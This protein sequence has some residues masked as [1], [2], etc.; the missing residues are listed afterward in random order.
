MKKILVSIFLLY[1]FYPLWATPIDIETAKK[2]AKNFISQRR[3][4]P[5]EVL[6]VVIEKMNGE[7]SF[8]VVNFHEGGW[9][10]VSSDNSTVPVLAYSI[11]GTY[12]LEDQKPEA[13]IEIIESYKEVIDVSKDNNQSYPQ[14]IQ[15]W[16]EL[17]NYTP[18]I[19]LKNYTPNTKLLNVPGRGHIKWSQDLNNDGGCEPSYNKFAPLGIYE[20]DCNK[21][22]VGCGAVAMGQIMWYWQW[23]LRSSFRT[24]NWNLMP[25]EL[26]N[27][28]TI[29]EGNEVALLL[30]DC[31]IASNMVYGY[32]TYCYGSWTTVNNIVD[33]L[34]NNFNYKT[35][36]KHVRS[37]W[38]YGNAWGDL[39]RSE[40]DNRRPVFYRGD[41]CDFCEEK[42]FFV[43]DG[44][45][46]LDP[47]YFSFNFGWGYP[48]G[49][50]NT[51]YFYLNNLTPYGS[52]FNK[53]QMAIVGISPSYFIPNNTNIVDLP[54]TSVTDYKFEAALQ[55]I[56]LPASGKSISVESGGELVFEA[57]NSIILKNGFHA[58]TDS[59]FSAKINPDYNQMKITVPLWP[60][61]FTPNGDGYNDN[62]CFDVFNAN[63]WEFEAFNSSG[64]PVF[65]SAGKIDGT[66]ICVWDGSGAPCNAAYACVIRFK[67]NYG[68]EVEKAYTITQ[69][70]G[71][72]TLE[73][74][75][76]INFKNSFEIKSIDIEENL[77]NG[78][79]F[80]I[81]PNPSSGVFELVFISNFAKNIKIFNTQG[82]LVY[83]ELNS[84][85]PIVTIN[86]ANSSTGIYLIK[87][88]TEK[89]T[90]TKKVILRK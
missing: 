68:Q 81:S 80:K 30:I 29:E 83:Q 22:P 20:C 8:Y 24:Y 44:Y 84:V 31:G 3:N 56:I 21:H 72:K 41:K 82:V 85:N 12:K 16:D 90:I 58:K 64:A 23:P 26:K 47:D 10:I 49:F 2:V 6:N 46:S 71:F 32:E 39:L 18:L 43:L 65:Q 77:L 88:E 45:D 37:D 9:V 86:L 62:V 42:H 34:K 38:N 89:Q 69:W 76:S 75:D 48:G 73:D 14:I 79:E 67:N 27:T 40:I 28:S 36:K 17:I 33:A 19:T 7:S 35:A 51:G 59:K 15:K 78:A 87:V 74:P 25:A 66:T 13:F 63:S 70:C 55:N 54:Y 1:L 11:E 53:N 52:D 50:Y 61:T 57:G 60:N 4:T 5:N